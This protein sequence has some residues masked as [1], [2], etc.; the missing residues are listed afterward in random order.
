[1]KLFRH[2]TRSSPQ[3]S[4][5]GRIP[6]KAFMP[7]GPSQCPGWPI[8]LAYRKRFQFSTRDKGAKGSTNCPR[9]P[10][11]LACCASISGSWQNDLT[12]PLFTYFSLILSLGD[13]HCFALTTVDA[14]LG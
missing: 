4:H 10:E 3:L 1:M 7:G 11:R 2:M 9:P 5:L 13:S 14:S 8:E 12:W 6:T